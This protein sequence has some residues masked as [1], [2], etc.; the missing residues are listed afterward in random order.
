LPTSGGR[1]ETDHQRRTIETY[2]AAL[3]SG[4]QVVVLGGRREA[5]VWRGLVAASGGT[6]TYIYRL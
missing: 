1:A 3:A 6:P 2:P 4:A 5:P